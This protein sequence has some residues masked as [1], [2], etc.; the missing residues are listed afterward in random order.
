VH[1]NDNEYESYGIR[2]KKL[3]DEDKTILNDWKNSN[4]SYDELKEKLKDLN[5]KTLK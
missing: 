1:L 3:S 4:I 5:S 2:I